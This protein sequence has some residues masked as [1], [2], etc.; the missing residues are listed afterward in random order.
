MNQ[1]A[2]DT[3]GSRWMLRFWSVYGGQ[4]LS[5]IGSGMNQFVLAWWIAETTDSVSAL[6]IC[7]LAAMLPVAVL[8]PLAGAVADLY[9]R[10]LVMLAAD[11][12]GASCVLALL[13]L[14]AE[15]A[16]ELWHA[17]LMMAVRSAMTAF[18]LPAAMASAPPL[19]PAKFFRRAVGM[20]QALQSLPLIVSAPLGAFAVSVMP[21]AWALLAD[22]ATT[23][24]AII[25]LLCLRIP[26]DIRVGQGR[27][28]L[29]RGCRDGMALVWRMPGLRRLYFLAA[30][31]AAATM[32]TFTLVPLMIM[33]KFGADVAHVARAEGLAALS[34][35][36]G[37][38][39]VAALA[40]RRQVLWVLLGY[41]AACLAMILTALVPKGLLGWWIIS[42]IAFV[43]GSAA[44]T[45]LLH[46]IVPN[47]FQGRVLSLLNGVVGAAAPIGLM[48]L[49]QLDE[50]LSLGKLFMLAGFLG[51]VASL[52]GFLS[53]A[54]VD[55]DCS[56][57]ADDS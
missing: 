4:A 27:R 51:T 3:V 38:S 28:R 50:T 21:A 43:C 39:L 45:G 25:P 7:G 46:G 36:L 40:P 24:L 18:Q 26:Q 23:L 9:S 53:S 41:S 30:A 19:A 49:T 52:T 57:K 10:R 17:C 20:S 29:W 32:P 8:S 33:D 55:L 16:M 6:A 2:P 44:V 14:F 37:G 5:L 11:A 22:A 35:M 15:G 34:M 47:H 13:I 48:L 31:V 42:G 12:I 54:L 56:R 1:L